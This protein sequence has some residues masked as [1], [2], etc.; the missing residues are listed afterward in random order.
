MC[1]INGF[2][3]KTSSTFNNAIT[4]MNSAISHRGPDTDGVWNDKNTGVVL[5]HQR[6]SIIDLS[7]AGHQ[8]MQSHS[9]QF[10]MTYNGEIYNHL[11]IRNELEK[12]NASINWRGTSDTETLLQAIEFWGI[13]ITL[14]K[15]VGMFAFAVWDKKNR[16]LTLARDRMGEKPIYFGW[17]GK[18][19]NKAF[20][21]GSELKALKVHPVFNREISRDVIALQLHHNCIPAPYSIYK[22]I[23]KL[24]PAHFLQLKENDLREGLLPNSKPYWSL[25]DVAVSGASNLL[26]NNISNIKDG[27]ENI[28][29]K[30]VKQQMISDVPLGAFL[31][32]GIDSSTIVALMQSQ[33]SQPIKT[34]TIGFH[35]QTYN[36]AKYAKDV[37]K[38]LGTDHTEFYVSDK[39]ALEVIPKLSNIYDEPFSDSS[40]IPTFLVSQLAKQNV[41]VSLSGDGGDELFC[42][43]NRYTMSKNWWN[44]LAMIPLPIRIFLSDRITNISPNSWNK[45]LKIFLRSNYL[46]NLGDL[47]YK[48]SRVLRCETLDNAYLKLTSHFDDPTKI[49]LKSRKKETRLSNYNSELEQFDNQQKMMIFDALTY[50]PDDILVKVDR[51]SMANSLEIRTPF[52]DHRVVEYSWKIPQSLKFKDSKGK[53]ILRQIL[54]KYV[55]KKIIERPKMGFGVPIDTWLRGELRDWAESLLNETRL[56]NDG[57]FDHK[58]IKKIWNEHLSKKKN[59][60]YHLWDILMFQSW[61]DKEKS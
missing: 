33:S 61:L 28:L 2:Y 12:S 54:N 56:K 42:G 1:G 6:L 8:P 25:N 49:V 44:K 32:G 27:L 34:F 3:S 9:D 41:K 14:Q 22:D 45:L 17:Q 19:D 30:T 57:Y 39:Q 16:C 40:Q 48:F 50:L 60:Q 35:E 58:H 13:E 24:L 15:I 18:G 52:L 11:E 20:L 38:Y 10:I 43:Y 59:W 55:P 4:N 29:K 51:A 37:A 7:K 23:Y 47:M 26:P 21:F 31:S 46:G 5:G 36:E 53:W